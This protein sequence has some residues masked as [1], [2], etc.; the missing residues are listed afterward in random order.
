[1]VQVLFNNGETTVINKEELRL[2]I[3]VSQ[4]KDVKVIGYKNI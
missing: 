3:A 4:H 2:F 1:M